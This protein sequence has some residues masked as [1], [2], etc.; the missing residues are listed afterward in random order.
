MH[1]QPDTVVAMNAEGAAGGGG[2]GI[3][4]RRRAALRDGGAAYAARREEVVQVASRLFREK[5]FESTTLNDVAAALGTDRASLYYYVGSK[6]ELLEEIVRRVLS[7]NL[8]MAQRV[9][10]RAASGRDKLEEI[11]REM[12]VSFDCN[13]PHIFVYIEDIGR[14][15][16]RDDQ[17]S[18]DVTQRSRRF[19]EV[20]VTIL[21]QGQSDGSLRIEAPSHLSAWALFG[22]INWCHRWY[23]PGGPYRPEDVA[24][25][26]TSIFLNG[27]SALPQTIPN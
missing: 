1:V 3:G 19:E 15:T 21:D 6:Q 25:A 4:R 22:M 10:E 14:I 26:F 13:F 12:V 5:G 24:S 7:A 27:M 18:R 2:S 20:V 17:W 8:A 9:L 23:H 16:R 11:V